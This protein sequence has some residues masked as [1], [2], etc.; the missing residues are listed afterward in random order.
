MGKTTFTLAMAS[1]GRCGSTFIGLPAAP[2]S[3]ARTVTVNL[4]EVAIISSGL[5]PFRY[6]T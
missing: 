3:R 5:A 6:V 4:F 1:I 2:H